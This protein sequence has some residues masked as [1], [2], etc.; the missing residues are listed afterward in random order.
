MADMSSEA[1]SPWHALT[2]DEVLRQLDSAV[3]GLGT[4]E[5]GS[6]LKT[7]GPNALPAARKKPAWLRFLAQFHNVLIYVL[8]AAAVIAGALGHLI[9]TA[10]IAA[11]VLIN[12]AI[13][14]VQEGKAE[15]AMEAIGQMLALKARVRRNGR[16]QTVPA[17]QLVPG[18]VVQVKSGDK[19]PA[20]I[21]LL[22]SHGLR[23][24][25]AALTGESLPVG[26][27]ATSVAEDTDLADRRCMIHSGVMTTNGQA[28]GVVVVTGADTELG[29]ISG[30]LQTV[31]TLT[32]PLLRRINAFARLL[33]MIILVVAALV[34]AVGALRHGMPLAEGL[35]AGIAL[36][37]AAIPEGLPAIITITLAIGVQRMA[38]RQ[39]I[40]RRLPAVETLGSVNIICSDKTGTLTRNELRVRA[41]ALAEDA[42]A[43]DA[44]ALDGP[45]GKALLRA[46]VLCNDFD[47]AHEGGDP[48]EKAL[49]EMVVDNGA[50]PGSIRDEHP[51]LALIPFSSEHK[52]MAALSRRLITVKGA[53]EAV[54]ERCSQALGENGEQPLDPDHW[55]RRLDKLTGRGLRVLAIAERQLDRDLDTLDDARDVQGLNLLGLVGFADPPREEV[56]MAIAACQSA[57]VRVKMITG[58][59]AATALAIARELKISGP[60][61]DVLSGREIDGMDDEALRAAVMATPVFARTTPEHK[62]RLVK[63]LQANHQVVAMTGDGANDAPALKRADIGVAM[64]IK[65]TEASRQAAEMVLADDNFATIVGGV[66]EGR[67]VYDNIRKAVLFVLPTNAAQ[68]AVIVL[69]VLAGFSLPITPVQILWVNMAVA[70]T[71]A[72]SLAFEP[73]EADI[74]RRR[75]RPMDQ[76]LLSSF[77]VARVLWV[78]ALLTA[79][80]FALHQWVL[81]GTGSEALARTMAVNVLVAGQIS[82][83]F[84]C[85]RWQL[86][87]LDPGMLGSN[88]WS[89][90]TAGLLIIMQLLFTYLPAAQLVFSTQAMPAHY[91][92][93]M[94][95]FAL[96]VFTLVEIEKAV[97]RRLGLAWA[98][99]GG[100][101]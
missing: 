95:A 73:L 101:H 3:H 52:Y 78:G 58:D 45:A 27:D 38:R 10:V 63:A 68:A 13:G 44:P 29:R 5:A 65:G 67:G 86:S 62:L 90:L 39:A 41:V 92:A 56:P 53:P 12:A 81:S 60:E 20:D 55:H 85:R 87:S 14:V 74:M 16:W 71:L 49:I 28:V 22:E 37:V 77:I 31:E 17:E 99:P 66:E 79:G 89:W 84:N 1:T 75:P 40:I 34:I 54:L 97:T 15:K 64:G 46:S 35:L 57:G 59:H 25:Q 8:L 30:M 50:D 23:V 33:T 6:R 51:R 2:G 11:V 100:A 32:T 82:Y 36:A 48:L 21:R 7:H 43:S 91:W 26:K 76:P 19:V 83:L 72:L 80:T 47:P 9:D 98:S 4:E 94:A 24:D 88:G 69:A 61:D 93:L 42:E 70:V 96:L 18:D